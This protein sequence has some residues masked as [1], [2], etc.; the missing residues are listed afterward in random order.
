MDPGPVNLKPFLTFDAFVTIAFTQ[1]YSSIHVLPP[2]DVLDRSPTRPAVGVNELEKKASNFAQV[3]R[4]DLIVFSSSVRR[5]SEM[6][7]SFSLT[8]SFKRCNAPS[9]Y[10]RALTSVSFTLSS[11]KSGPT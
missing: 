11:K 9:E 1:R 7:L 10:S 8:L 2:D 6:A 3:L 5:A 4:T